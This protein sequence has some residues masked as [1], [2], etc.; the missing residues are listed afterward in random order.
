MH[1]NRE[2]LLFF[3]PFFCIRFC[4]KGQVGGY[5]DEMSEEIIRKFEQWTE[6]KKKELASE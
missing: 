6:K 4:R 2:L 5:R 3:K 1:N